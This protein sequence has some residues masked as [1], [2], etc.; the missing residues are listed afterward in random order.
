MDALVRH[1]V[2]A[3]LSACRFKS[4]RG[5]HNR[6]C[7]RSAL[8]RGV[9]QTP[10]DCVQERLLALLGDRRMTHGIH[11]GPLHVTNVYR[12]ELLVSARDRP[13]I[14]TDNASPVS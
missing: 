3:Q 14:H 2:Q 8:V 10:C 7:P 9:G 5:R 13:Q 12:V 4:G 6:F 1:R 11:E